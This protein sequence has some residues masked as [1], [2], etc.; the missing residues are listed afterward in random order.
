MYASTNFE[1]IWM[2]LTNTNFQNSDKNFLKLGCEISKLLE[3]AII[4]GTTIKLHFSELDC[5]N[6]L[7]LF[8]LL[9]HY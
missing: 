2:I 4:E 6:N 8:Y 1:L 9:R 5:F 7:L 3:L